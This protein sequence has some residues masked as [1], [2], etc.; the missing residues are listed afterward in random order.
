MYCPNCGKENKTNDFCEDCNTNLVIVRQFLYRA[1]SKA[2]RSNFVSRSGLVS[3][4]VS[5]GFAWTFA[6]LA[7]FVL[8][9]FL[10]SMFI[11]KDIDTNTQ[12]YMAFSV[13]IALVFFCGIPLLLGLV[14][15]LK[16]ITSVRKN[17]MDE[18]KK[19]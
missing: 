12:T 14:L 10:A 16:D 5:E 18:E 2:K 7:I 19:V 1:D 13:I 17:V 9:I 11:T 6:A 4:T 8:I 3:I 15:L